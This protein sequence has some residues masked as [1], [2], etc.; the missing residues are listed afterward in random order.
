MA[1]HLPSFIKKLIDEFYSS[2]ITLE[3]K[4]FKFQIKLNLL[5]LEINHDFTRR[6]T[7][8]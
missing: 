3:C 1:K 4:D 6:D 5:T 8:I 7:L 2:S